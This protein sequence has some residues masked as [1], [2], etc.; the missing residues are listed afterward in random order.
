MLIVG[1][2]VGHEDPFVKFN[3]QAEIGQ[4]LQTTG[5]YHIGACTPLVPSA[6]PCFNT[7]KIPTNL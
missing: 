1:F 2:S 6:T 4:C 3:L 7:R 5:Y